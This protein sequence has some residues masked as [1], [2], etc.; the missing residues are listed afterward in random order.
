[1]LESPITLLKKGT[2]EQAFSCD[3]C[4]I[5]NNI[6]FAENLHVTASRSL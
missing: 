4:E 2:P 3:F 1:M 5:F 6:F